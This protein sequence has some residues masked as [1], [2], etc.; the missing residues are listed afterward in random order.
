[1]E[2]ESEGGEKKIFGGGGGS[3]A[4]NQSSESWDAEAEQADVEG[5]NLSLSR[6]L[7]LT[8]VWDRPVL[9]RHVLAELTV[10][11]GKCEVGSRPE[12]RP[13][14]PAL[15]AR[16]ALGAAHPHFARPSTAKRSHYR[17]A[18]R[19]D[20]VAMALQR[21]L[22][23]RRSQVVEVLLKLPGIDTSGVNM[24]RLFIQPDDLRYLRNNRLLQ[25]CHQPR[26]NRRNA[27]WRPFP[28]CILPPTDLASCSPPLQARLHSHISPAPY[29]Q[30]LHSETKRATNYKDFKRATV[31]FFR[32]VSPFHASLLRSQAREALIAC[33]L[34]THPYSHPTI[35]CR[36][37]LSA[38]T[39]SSGSS[40]M[41]M[42]HS[43]NACGPNATALF[44]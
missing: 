21:A 37:A 40:A 44:T 9:A 12:V 13:C 38:A 32:S 24:G 11:Q 41:A 4:D 15:S 31:G 33:T 36:Y 2:F 19:V 29:E 42:R 20:Q 14:T 8:V 7:A 34:H 22:E 5:M 18:A 25:A 17:S 43:P 10:G 30:E 1:M 23:L 16:S 3:S 28:P 6:A 35:S 27:A 26:N 39:S